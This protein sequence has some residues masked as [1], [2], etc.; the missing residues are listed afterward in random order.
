LL[1]YPIL[2][3]FKH[4]NVFYILEK[5]GLIDKVMRKLMILPL[6]VHPLAA[7]ELSLSETEA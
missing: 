4:A 1:K 6:R 2:L 7:G 5:S 3:P